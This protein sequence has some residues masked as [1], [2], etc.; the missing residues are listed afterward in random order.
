MQSSEVFVQL[1]QSVCVLLL[2]LLQSDGDREHDF[3][4]L[5][6]DHHLMTDEAGSG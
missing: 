5:V 2:V 1:V 3:G 4:L 6:Y